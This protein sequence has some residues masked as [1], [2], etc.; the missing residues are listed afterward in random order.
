M[1]Y[2]D[3]IEEVHAKIRKSHPELTRNV[4]KA[5]VRSILYNFNRKIVKYI[6][7]RCY[8]DIKFFRI[9]PVPYQLYY[10]RTRVFAIRRKILGD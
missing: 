10:H 3:Y 4:T 5:M 8:I 1:T 2:K 6:K 7:L 9:H